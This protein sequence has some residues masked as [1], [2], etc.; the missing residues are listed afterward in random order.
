LPPDAR[1]DVEFDAAT[2]DGAVDFR[3]TGTGPVASPQALTIAR[4]ATS[5]SPTAAV[6]MSSEHDYHDSC[7]MGWRLSA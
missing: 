6:G 1:C 3:A 5:I 2:E 7:A 4:V